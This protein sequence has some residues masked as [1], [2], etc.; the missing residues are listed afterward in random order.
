MLVFLVVH[1]F[2]LDWAS[3]QDTF[4]RHIMRHERV[5]GGLIKC[6]VRIYKI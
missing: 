2:M 3:D 5:P 6:S 4:V 1:L